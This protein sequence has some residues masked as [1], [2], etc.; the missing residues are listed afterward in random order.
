[1]THKISWNLYQDPDVMPSLEWNFCS[2]RLSL[3]AAQAAAEQ[4]VYGSK[5]W[6]GSTAID[7]TNRGIRG[8]AR[9]RGLDA[10]RRRST[11]Y[12]YV[13]DRSH[14]QQ[15][16]GGIQEKNTRQSGTKMH[17]RTKSWLVKISRISP[18]GNL[19]HGCSTPPEPAGCRW[20]GKAGPLRCGVP[21]TVQ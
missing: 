19:M 5:A 6:L 11:S 17:G 21:Y 16:Q 7:E 10:A 15:H 13:R 12:C 14:V 8:A 3:R 20:S 18:S 9:A 1:M 4:A 2:F